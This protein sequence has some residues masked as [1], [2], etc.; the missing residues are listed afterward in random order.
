VNTVIVDR[1]AP[2][3]R[4]LRDAAKSTVGGGPNRPNQAG[5]NRIDRSSWDPGFQHARSPD[6]L[7]SI[8]EIQTSP[9]YVLPANLLFCL[10]TID[11]C[12]R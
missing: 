9:D 7:D 4:L 3:R 6:T 1:F 12:E 8:A 5:N 2:E 10:S 11:E